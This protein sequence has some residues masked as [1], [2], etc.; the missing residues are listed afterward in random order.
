LSPI[1]YPVMNLAPSGKNEPITV[2]IVTRITRKSRI[3]E[4]E[5]WMEGI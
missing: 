5:E 4:F 3:R 2:V 1:V